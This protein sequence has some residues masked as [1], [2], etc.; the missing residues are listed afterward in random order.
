[1]KTGSFFVFLD[2]DGMM[3]RLRETPCNSLVKNNLTINTKT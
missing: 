1:M 2:I 3:G